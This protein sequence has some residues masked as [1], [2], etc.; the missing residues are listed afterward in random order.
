[1]KYLLSTGRVTQDVVTYIKD[2]ILFNMILLKDE[3]P[4]FDGGSDELIPD[5]ELDNLEGHVRAI[6]SDILARIRKSFTKINLSIVDVT[7][8]NSIVRVKININDV[9]EIYDIKKAN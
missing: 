1:M 8:D 3:I 4:D 5:L 9:I 7:I 2:I 6:V